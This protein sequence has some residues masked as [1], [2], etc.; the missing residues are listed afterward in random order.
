M[1]LRDGKFYEGD[2]LVPLEHGNPDQIA[3]MNRFLR[4]HEELKN[5]KVLDVSYQK[6]IVAITHFSCICGQTIWRESSVD[7]EE[8]I[9]ELQGICTCKKCQRK[10]EVFLD[11]DKNELMVKL[12]PM[13]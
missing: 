13:P 9:G 6:D 1:I 3:I 2:K 8:E 4:L 10:Y 12:K 11:D 7:E 5:G